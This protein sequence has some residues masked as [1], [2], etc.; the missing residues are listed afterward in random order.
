MTLFCK[1]SVSFQECTI[2]ISIYLLK[3]CETGS[4]CWSFLRDP[5]TSSLATRGPNRSA[6]SSVYGT[7]IMFKTYK[8]WYIELKRIISKNLKYK[9]LQSYYKCINSRLKSEIK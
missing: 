7:V 4:V 5:V 1:H 8:E 2:N 3:N 6:N 9:L